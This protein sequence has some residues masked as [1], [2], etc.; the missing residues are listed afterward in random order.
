MLLNSLS[1][2]HIALLFCLFERIYFNASHPTAVCRARVETAETWAWK[3]EFIEWLMCSAE[4][5]N[6]LNIHD[7]GEI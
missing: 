3:G 7:Y 5:I 1:D 6:K 4:S 2:M